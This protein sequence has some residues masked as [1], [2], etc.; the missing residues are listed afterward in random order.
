[1]REHRVE[2]VLGQRFP[3]S[4]DCEIAAIQPLRPIAHVDVRW[5][6]R[7]VADR[8]REHTHAL[9]MPRES[10]DPARHEAEHRV[11]AVEHLRE[12]DELHARS[13]ASRLRPSA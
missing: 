3:G 11:V 5:Q 1:V 6:A 9:T 10:F 8:E 4:H 13:P 7:D 2:T 12:K